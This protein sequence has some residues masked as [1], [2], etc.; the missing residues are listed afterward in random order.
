MFVLCVSNSKCH[1]VGFRLVLLASDVS[2]RYI[3]F[4]VLLYQQCFHSSKDVLKVTM[5]K[6]LFNNQI[7]FVPHLIFPALGAMHPRILS[8]IKEKKKF[9]YRRQ[10]LSKLSYLLIVCNEF[11]VYKFLIFDHQLSLKIPK[12]KIWN[13]LLSVSAEFRRRFARRKRG[14]RCPPSRNYSPAVCNAT[15]RV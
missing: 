6:S 8:D 14:H 1:C 5:W 10:I 7:Y 3:I 13:L 12:W 15:T 9:S 11:Y 4:K 2:F